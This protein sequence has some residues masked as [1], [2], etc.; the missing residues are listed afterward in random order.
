VLF[1]GV[2]SAENQRM[3]KK[4]GF[5]LRPDLPAPP[6]AVLLTKRRRISGA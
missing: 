5:R 2:A 1:T 3:Y 6:G 4:A